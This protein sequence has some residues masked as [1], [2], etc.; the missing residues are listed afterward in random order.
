MNK[1]TKKSL[2]KLAISV[3]VIALIVVGGYLLAYSF[4]WTK[5][6]RRELQAYIQKQ[7]LLAP[8]VFIGITFLQVTLVPIPGSITILTGNYLFGLWRSFL[9]SYIGLMLGSIVAFALGRWVGRPFVNWIAGSE[10]KVEEWLKKLKGKEKILLFFM[11]LFPFFPDDILCAVA[12]LLPI[13]WL[14][15]LL[16]QLLTRATSVGGTLL[17]VSGEF[18]PY[19]GWG[20]FVIILIGI[21]FVFL[22]ALSMRYANEI[23]QFFT[24]LCDKIQNNKYLKNRG[25]PKE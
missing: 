5:L 21:S 22:F 25:K 24:K 15:F 23:N 4:G 14:E 6:T 1:E 7:G 18:I 11:F 19:H 20:L 3:L 16:M 9:Y 13:S 10:E 12:G 8:I 17:F 2:I